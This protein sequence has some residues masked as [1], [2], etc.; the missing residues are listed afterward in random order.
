[1]IKLIAVLL[2]LA[3]GQ[4]K[5]FAYKDTFE[6]RTACEE[7]LPDLTERF[8]D[9]MQAAYGLSRDEIQVALKCVGDDTDP[10]GDIARILDEMNKR[11]GFGH[12]DPI[13]LR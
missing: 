3:S 6:T 12:L 1:M 8:L 2:V 10:F 13:R 7:A 11:G 5:E 4:T 9:A